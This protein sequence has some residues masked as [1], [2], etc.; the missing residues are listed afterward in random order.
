MRR[1]NDA[2]ASRGIQMHIWRAS[3]C[4]LFFVCA[5]AR[6]QTAVFAAVSMPLAGQHAVH[7]V[8]ISIS[9]SGLVDVG[10]NCIGCARSIDFVG[11]PNTHA[12]DEQFPPNLTDEGGSDNAL[13]SFAA[14]ISK[15]MAMPALSDCLAPLNGLRHR[16]RMPRLHA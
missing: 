5:I 14:V 1:V 9:P 6:A 10:G 16:D 12:T 15:P 4:V 2:L 3:L 13:G 8:D 11:T 7:A